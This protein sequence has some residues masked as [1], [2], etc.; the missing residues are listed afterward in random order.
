MSGRVPP[1]EIGTAVEPC[2]LLKVGEIVLKGGNRQYFERLLQANLR[3][4]LRD[5]G[6]AVRVWNRNGVIVLRLAAE[7]GDPAGP[8]AEAAMDKIAERVR[9]V[10]GIARVCRAVRVAKD[11]GPGHRHRGR[12]GGRPDRLV[13]GP[14]PAPGQAVPGH[15]GR[16][17]RADRHPGPAGLRLPGQPEAPGL[18]PV[19]RGGRPRGVRVHRRVGRPGRAAGRHERPRAGA[20]VRR[21]RLTG[22]RVPDDAPRAALRLPALL[23]HAADRARVGVQGVRADVP[24]GPVPVRLPAVGGGVRQDTAEAGLVRCEPAADRRPAPADA[25]DR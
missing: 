3:R 7:H 24:A 8:A 17:G 15:L 4:A 9:S 22:G 10:M 20:D 2:V 23:R 21:D 11:T 1:A 25:Q 5:V 19:R 18:H 12:A 6:A 16:A 13:R 14:G